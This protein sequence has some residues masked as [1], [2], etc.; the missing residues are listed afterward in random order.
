MDPRLLILD[1]SVHPDLYTPVQ[2]WSSFTGLQAQVLRPETPIPLDLRQ[3]T[4]AFVTGSEASIVAQDSWIGR[5]CEVVRELA[6]L[7]VPTLAS[8]FGHQML[9]KALWGRTFVRRSPTPEF[10]WV[11]V[12]LTSQGEADPLL[13]GVCRTFHTYSAHFDEIAPLP[14]DFRVL[15]LSSRCPHAI[16]RVGDLPMWGLQHH[17]EISIPQGS[18]LLEALRMM[19]PERLEL[20]DMSTQPSAQ[21]SL[22]IH[23]LVK[24]FLAIG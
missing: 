20:I 10:G 21:D 16:V 15:G 22:Q 17:P 4:H 5:Q 2:H 8:C 18:A 13:A 24:N 12:E 14:P 3:F 7:R 1:N 23:P 6:R 9:A 19:M 11:Q